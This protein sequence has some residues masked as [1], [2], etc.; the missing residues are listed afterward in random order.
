MKPILLTTKQ[1]C[2]MVGLSA[3]FIRTLVVLDKFPKPVDLNI[4]KNLYRY[5]EVKKWAKNLKKKEKW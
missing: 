5:K 1:V 3:S 2:E 4:Y